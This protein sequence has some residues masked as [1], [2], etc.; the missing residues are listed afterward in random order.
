MHFCA[1]TPG[2][3]KRAPRWSK[4]PA[5][6]ASGVTRRSANGRTTSSRKYT[7]VGAALHVKC[8][9]I[10]AFRLGAGQARLMQSRRPQRWALRKC[11]WRELNYF[12]GLCAAD[13]PAIEQCDC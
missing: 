1:T 4:S 8:A 5:T 12:G 6:F 7:A 13:C 9:F 3:W 2:L 10:D 11:F